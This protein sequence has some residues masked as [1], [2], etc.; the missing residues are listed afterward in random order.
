[1]GIYD[2]EYYR[3]EGPSFLE[4]FS[5]QGK[6]CK[7]LI[8][9]N[10]ICFFLQFAFQ[11]QAAERRGGPF[12]DPDGQVTREA[13]SFNFASTFD[14]NVEAVMHGQVWRLLTYAFLHASVGHIFWNMLFLWWFG[15]DVESLYGPR[16]FTLM[17][18]TSAVVG[19]LFFTLGGLAAVHG[20]LGGGPAQHMLLGDMRCVGASGAVMAALVLCALHYPS[21]IILLFFILPV[22]IWLFVGFKVAQDL[23]GFLGVGGG[24]SRTAFSVHLG[25]AAFA[26]AYYKLHWRLDRFWPSARRWMRQRSSP[27]LRVYHEQPSERVAASVPP[28]GESFDEHLEAKVDAVL[29]KVK[30]TGMDSL[31]ESEKQLLV[32]ASEVFKRRRS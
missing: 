25:G 30:R 29:E 3:R 27:R 24:D 2:R 32:R 16:E 5:T 26:F 10:V 21:K 4:S 17:Y 15:K 12:D 9:I 6:A 19:G 31:T 28:A 11:P 7:W 20:A 23:F 8:I 1:M 22:P 13:D 14:L 18:L